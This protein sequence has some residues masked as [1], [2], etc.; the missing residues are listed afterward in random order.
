MVDPNKVLKLDPTVIVN[1]P[2]LE[3]TVVDPGNTS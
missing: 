2:K 3:A 1:F